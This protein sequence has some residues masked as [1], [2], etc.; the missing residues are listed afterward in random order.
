MRTKKNITAHD[1]FPQLQEWRRYFHKHPELSFQEKQTSEKIIEVLK[2]FGV[3]KIETNVGGYGV[4]ATLTT[5]DGPVIGLRADMDALPILEQADVEYASSVPGVMHACGHDAH[6][7]ILLGAARLLS[8]KVKDQSWRGTIKLIFQPAEESCDEQGESGAV[9]VLKS[10]CIDDLSAVLALHMC[11]WQRRGT[12]QLHDGPSMANNDEFHLIIKGR[13]GHGGYP[14]HTNDP[15]WMSTFVLQT[16]YSLSG[17]KLDPLQVGALSIGQI[18]G[19]E[20]HNIIP[21]K[22]EIKGTIRSY[23]ERV[24]DQLVEEVRRAAEI[25]KPMG[26]EYELMIQR[27]EPAL[28][29]NLAINQVLREA[30]ESM[31]IIE[32]PF[33]MGSEDFSYITREIPGSM[34]FLGCGLE[35]ER[36]LHHPRFDIDEHSMVDGV[37]ILLKSVESLLE[38]EG[39]RL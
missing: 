22:V 8:E 32:K 3:F 16:L 5:G 30:A 23:E 10:G 27:G 7:A 25:V 4:I 19:G 9:K 38:S 18:A 31:T 17:R 14:Q 28:Y 29:N 21:D 24:R 37:T 34:F 36:G 1:I 20:A 6:I 26:G 12:V 13:G 33:G 2:S 39:G 35:E 11:P 15:L